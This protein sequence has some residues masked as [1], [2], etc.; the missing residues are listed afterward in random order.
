MK[1]YR[2]HLMLCAGTACV[3]NNSFKIKEA[4][5]KEIKKHG[6]QDEILVVMTG[7]N[8]FCAV[9]PI[10]VVK[11]DGIF[12]QNLTE[13]DIPYLVEEHFL[14]GRP[15]QKLMYFPPKEKEVI[16]KMM[17][18]GF[19]AHQTLIA[20]KNRG[21]IDPEKIDEYIARDGYKALA[22]ALTSMTPEQVIR[23]IKDSGL[24]GRGGA[25]FPTGLKWEFCRKSPGDEKYIICNADEG[26][27]GAFMDR[28]IIESDPHLVLEGMIIGAYGIG[29]NQGYVYIRNEYPLAMKRLEIAINQ[30]REYGLF[31]ENIFE[32]GF[33]F[34]IMIRKGAGAFVCGEETALIASIEG[35]P[36][37][38]RQRPPF[39]AQS[40][41]W[42][43]P[44]NINNV[45]TWATVP[46]IILR[47]YEWFS[48]IG[49]EKSKGTKVFSLVGKINNTGLV[50]VPMGITLRE[51][52][53]D[54]GGGIPGGKKFKAVQTGG[55]SG[56]CIP[57]DLID[58]PVDYEQLTRV[59]S[60]MGS[61]GMIVMD[62]DTCVVD[63]ARYFI[64]FT[65]D[66]SCGKCTSCREGS[67]ALLEIL[68]KI[69]N[70]EGEEGDLI[71][72]EE[73]G[74]A[75]KDASLCG[76]GQTLPNP[77]L[78]TLKYFRDEYEAHI[79]DK[80][81][82][83]GVCKALIQY[84]V[85]KEKCT[86]CLLCVKSCPQNAISGKKKEPQTIDQDKCIKCNMC[87]EVCKFNAILKG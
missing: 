70:G 3:S 57:A 55:P 82:P 5:E 34:D 35:K 79:K 17:D 7:C 81:C 1:T 26:D 84:S 14:K 15:V 65:N 19:F 49:T 22:K 71:L 67:E 43:K 51:I 62:E 73:L 80:K 2:T 68:N 77:V 27:P 53:Y 21:L 36:P 29:A 72:L 28:S 46:T 60:I 30:A 13:E 18:I 9:G 50:E 74:K 40:G 47:G 12:Y 25:G 32:S 20:L 38:P 39:P 59:G 44:T 75:I 23:E 42:G 78:S 66:E 86:G 10:M 85:D 58:L 16:P 48:A 37:E 24:R 8:G 69:C 33:N 76:L 45:E 64:K 4:L 61:G 41:V 87:Y 52:I 83:A 6:L 63:I 56:G 54:I 11:P 31:G